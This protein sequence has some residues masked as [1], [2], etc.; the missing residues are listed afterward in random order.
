MAAIVVLADEIRTLGFGSIGFSFTPLGI[1]FAH[2]MRIVKFINT[3]NADIIIS[4]DGITNH[5]YVPAGGFVLYDF[6]SNDLDQAGWFM[7]VETQVYVKLATG[8]ASGGVFLVC[9]HGL[10]E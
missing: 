10:G 7:R 9:Y 6:S 5:D 8:A 3:A 1:P 2:P 4:Y